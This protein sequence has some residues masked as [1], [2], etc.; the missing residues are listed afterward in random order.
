MPVID[1]R[2]VD[3]RSRRRRRRRFAA[4]APFASI[5]QHALRRRDRS[6]GADQVGDHRAAV[7]RVDASSASTRGTR[8]SR[9]RGSSTPTFTIRA[10][11]AST[12]RARRDTSSTSIS[13]CSSARHRAGS[14]GVSDRSAVDSR[15]RGS[16][17]RA[18]GGR[19]ALLN[20]G[21]AW[22]NKRWPPPRLGGA[23]DGASRAHG[24]AIGRPVGTGRSAISPR[25]SWR[26]RP[27]RR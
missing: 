8:A 13:G 26:L 16:M 10:A 12:R 11:R 20:P 21:A 17:T 25:R 14:A 2:L 5:R 27:A 7:G 4:A 23:G 6:P 18:A 22:P 1:R 24:S 15:R 19:Y 9:W 3:Q